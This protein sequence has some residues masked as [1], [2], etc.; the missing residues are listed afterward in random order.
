MI[1]L[2]TELINCN[3][4]LFFEKEQFLLDLCEWRHFP[5]TLTHRTQVDQVFS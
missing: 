3:Y 1:V 5:P 2:S 4:P